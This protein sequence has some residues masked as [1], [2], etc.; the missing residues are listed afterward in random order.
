MSDTNPTRAETGM[1]VILVCVGAFTALAG[2]VWWKEQV[3]P[4]LK[5][6]GHEK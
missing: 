6:K 3:K 1:K 5:G 2:C 4:Q